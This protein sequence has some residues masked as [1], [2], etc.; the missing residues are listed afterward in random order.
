MRLAAAAFDGDHQGRFLAADKGARAQADVDVKVKAAAQDVLSQQAVGL[1]LRDR[2]LKAVD[3][4]G[5]LG[6]HIDVAL[7]GPDGIARDGH[8]L[9]HRVRVALQN[10]AVHEGARVALIGVADDVFGIRLAFR[11]QLPLDAG[12]EAAAAAPAQA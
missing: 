8:G 1:G 5:V 3:G 2:D 11:G 10:G 9:Q 7:I 6:A 12:G 4:N